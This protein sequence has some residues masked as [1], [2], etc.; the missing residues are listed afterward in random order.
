MNLVLEIVCQRNMCQQLGDAARVRGWSKTIFLFRKFL[1]DG[2]RIFA[3][4][5]KTLA[6][7]FGAIVIQAISP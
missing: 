7:L 6:Q 2:N 3:D 1:R 4:G 5:A